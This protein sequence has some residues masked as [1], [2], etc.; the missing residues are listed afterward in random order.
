M[1]AP[2]TRMA[3]TRGSSHRL[4]RI[5]PGSLSPDCGPLAGARRLP[6]LIPGAVHGSRTPTAGTRNGQQPM[7]S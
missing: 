2:A 7:V 1:S 3:S 6:P 5:T 4:A